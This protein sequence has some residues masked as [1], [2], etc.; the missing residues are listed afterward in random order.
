M[1]DL[2]RLTATELAALV[3][4]GETSAVEV[5]QAHL[6][7]IAAVFVVRSLMPPPHFARRRPAA[8]AR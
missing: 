3:A 1:T 4:S 6:D 5:A 2:T 7:R 8:T